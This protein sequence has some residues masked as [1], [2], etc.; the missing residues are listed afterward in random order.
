MKGEQG[1]TG[2]AMPMG[3]LRQAGPRYEKPRKAT[4]AKRDRAKAKRRRLM[5]KHSR[6]RNRV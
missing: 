4:K 5:V 3:P 6:R 2:H 1:T